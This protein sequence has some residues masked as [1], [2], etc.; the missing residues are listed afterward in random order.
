MRSR[1][2]S[3]YLFRN[4]SVPLIKLTARIISKVFLLDG[5]Q[6]LFHVSVNILE[7]L[8]KT[9]REKEGIYIRVELENEVTK[10]KELH[11]IKKGRRERE[12]TFP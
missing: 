3:V 8:R 2:Y 5:R 12:L 6:V 4:E 7:A 11:E 1:L 9:L 10:E